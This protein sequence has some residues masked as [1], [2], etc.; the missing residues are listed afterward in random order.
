MRAWLAATFSERAR[1]LLLSLAIAVTMWYYVGS[2]SAPPDRSAAASLHLRDVEV[3]ITGLAEGWTAA[4]QPHAVDL[5]MRGPAA[6]FTLR[7][8]QVRVIA[9][10]SA[11]PPGSHQVTLRIQTPRDVTTAKATPPAVQVTLVRP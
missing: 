1:L 9:D 4:A 3:T 2:T 6:I 5:E 11:L 10:V 7:A 8:A